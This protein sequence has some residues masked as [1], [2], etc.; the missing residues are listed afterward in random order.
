[1]EGAASEQGRKTMKQLTILIVEDDLDDLA[2]MLRMLEQHSSTRPV[3][4]MDGVEALNFLLDEFKEPPSLVVLDLKLPKL[5]GLAVLRRIRAE[6]RTRHLP[7]IVLTGSQ[8]ERDLIEAYRQG[9]QRCVQKPLL[10]S[11]MA[12]CLQQFR[13]EWLLPGP[14]SLPS[15]SVAA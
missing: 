14:L 10:P 3:V 7:V 9:A 6:K 11:V 8:E 2:L 1:M 13:L 5:P 12:E 4:A 15:P